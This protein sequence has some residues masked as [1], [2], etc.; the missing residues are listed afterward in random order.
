MINMKNYTQVEPRAQRYRALV[1]FK[2]GTEGLICV[3]SSTGSVLD[4]YEEAFEDL[5]KEQKNDVLGLQLQ[6]W[7]GTPDCGRWK[8]HK[9]LSIPEPIILGISAKRR[10]DDLP[11]KINLSS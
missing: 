1:Q 7:E 8:P 3:G 9:T 5:Y 2:D 6:K 4:Q 11:I 10:V